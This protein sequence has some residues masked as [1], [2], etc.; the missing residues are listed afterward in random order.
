MRLKD[1]TYLIRPILPVDVALYPDFF[2]KVSPE[3]IRM[4]FMAPRKHSR[5]SSLRLTQ[6][7]YH[8]DMAF[9]ALNPAG[10]LASR[11]SPPIPAARWPNT[12]C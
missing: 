6:L 3:D 9:V 10:D 12:P 2:E 1:G 5:N 4:R 11:A 8:R 7:D